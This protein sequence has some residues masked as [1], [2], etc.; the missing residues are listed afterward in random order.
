MYLGKYI[1]SNSNMHKANPFIK[2]LCLIIFIIILFLSYD[3]K[4]NLIVTILLVFLL[5]N[6]GYIKSIIKNIINLKWFLLFIFIIN[7]LFKVDINIILITILRIIY[8][9][10]YTNIFLISTTLNDITYSL[11]VLF[12]PLKVFNIKVN[13]MAFS[14]TLALRFIPTL[15]NH[16]NRIL[17]AQKSRGVNYN[18]NLKDRLISLKYLIIPLFNISFK[19]SDNLADMMEIKL[20]D[21]DKKRTRYEKLNIKLFDILMIVIHISLIFIIK[22]V[23]K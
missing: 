15:F 18:S 23:I 4:F 2:L 19:V 14:I 9:V 1:K 22:G 21:I 6:T 8:I 16:A 12:S 10:I 20:Y 17:K 11:Q 3:L 13:R 5:L 7:L